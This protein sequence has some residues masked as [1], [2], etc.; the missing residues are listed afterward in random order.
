MEFPIFPSFSFE[1]GGFSIPCWICRR[2]ICLSVNGFCKGGTN[3]Q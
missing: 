3:G 1:N 2:L